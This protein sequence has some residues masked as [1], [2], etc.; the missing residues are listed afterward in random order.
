MKKLTIIFISIAFTLSAFSQGNT[1]IDNNSLI[2]PS[3]EF[4][5]EHSINQA[6]P[7]GFPAP[8]NFTVTVIN[9][10]YEFNWEMPAGANPSY[11]LIYRNGL[12]IDSITLIGYSLEIYFVAFNEF[13][14]VAG[15]LNPDGI[16][17]PSNIEII[18]MPGGYDMYY[19]EDFE[20]CSINWY[21]T[22]L[23]GNDNWYHCGAT[24]Y[25][26]S[27]SLGWDSQSSGAIT[28]C[29]PKYLYSDVMCGGP[30]ISFRYKIPGN[31]ANYDKL[32]IYLDS[33]L[34]SGPL[35]MTNSW[36]YYEM[37]FFVEGQFDF[38][39]EAQSDDG[40]GIYID[41]FFFDHTVGVFDKGENAFDE[42][43]I[44][45]NPVTNTLNVQINSTS[46]HSC[47]FEVLAFNGKMVKYFKR[48]ME[49]GI[50]TLSLNVKDLK[51]GIYFLKIISNG[52]LFIRKFII[53]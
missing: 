28:K 40:A 19:F 5:M 2:I 37:E 11:Y 31:G 13:Y 36:A 49:T 46:N 38:Y 22:P 44:F 25:E 43:S 23:M 33:E 17:D 8:E 14:V 26:G 4:E 6:E 51:S 45:P 3:S 12:L 32:Y 39:F 10:T 27:Y 42:T 7:L 21:S 48:D 34:F 24:S 52:D 9:F 35:E 50:Q 15:Y 18:S 41:N 47:V 29:G 30:R 20:Y 16:S 1:L 53:E